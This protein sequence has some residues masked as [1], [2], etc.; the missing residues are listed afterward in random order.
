MTTPVPY[1]SNPSQLKRVE[2]ENKNWTNLRRQNSVHWQDPDFSVDRVRCADLTSNQLATLDLAHES[3]NLVLLSQQSLERHISRRSS[4]DEV[5]DLWRLLRRS[6]GVETVG[7]SRTDETSSLSIPVSVS[8]A[9][10]PNTLQRMER[11]SSL[12]EE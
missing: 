3:L 1:Q 6:R 5:E 2:S 7:E 8:S 4:G 9:N 10:R 12:D 11:T